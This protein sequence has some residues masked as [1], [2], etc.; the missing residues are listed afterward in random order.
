MFTRSRYQFGWLEL[1]K[2]K[3]RP[4]VWLWRYRSTDSGGNRDKDAVVIGDVEQ[5]PTKALAWKAAEGLRLSVNRENPG[6]QVTFRALID[7]YLREQIP[8]R[9]VTA[10]KYRSWI[11]HH[12][13]PQWGDYPIAK[14]KPVLVE[15]WISKLELAPKSK[16]HVRSI[17]HI[18]FQWA[19]KW[20]LMDLQINP[21]KLV[22][23]KGSSK[24]LREPVT[25]TQKQFHH[26]LR[27]VV[28]PFRTMCVV[29]MC[30]GLRASELVGLQWTD[31]DWKNGTVTIQRGVVIGR[32]DEVKTRYSNK[33]IPL[34]P[35]LASM[36]LSYRRQA[37]PGNWVFPSS[38]TGRP[39]WPWT[40]QRNHLLPAGIKAGLGRIGW[41]T[42]R[43]SYSTMLRALRVDVKVQ[44]ELL[45]HADI[46][47]TLN[48]YTQAVP[49]ALR[50][51][52]SRVVQMVLPER[53]SA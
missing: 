8:Q 26:V 11:T 6:T 42:F 44:Q 15:E 9:H 3:R 16:G 39:W 18:L 4:S 14:V 53:K 21:M 5:Y 40:I 49:E 19:M 22:H 12:I 29:A 50:K 41:H 7:R 45:R 47:T 37:S 28:E 36:M 24:R 31:F 27:F 20:E 13:Q 51:A 43:H 10:S 34:D 23:V 46:R 52:N 17:M 38:R 1:R 33:A 25:L 48:I 30:L 35:V 32:V 2:R